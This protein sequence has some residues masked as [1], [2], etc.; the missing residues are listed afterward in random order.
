MKELN[1]TPLTAVWIAIEDGQLA[2]LGTN[3][4]IP[5]DFVCFEKMLNKNRSEIQNESSNNNVTISDMQLEEQLEIHQQLEISTQQQ[6][7]NQ[8]IDTLQQTESQE[9]TDSE[10]SYKEMEITTDSNSISNSLDIIDN[11]NITNNI[12]NASIRN[13]QQLLLQPAAIQGQGPY[14]GNFFNHN[15]KETFL[16]SISNMN[17]EEMIESMNQKSLIQDLKLNANGDTHNNFQ[18]S[19]NNGNELQLQQQLQTVELNSFNNQ[20]LLQSNNHKNSNN[21]INNNNERNML[22][23]S[24]DMNGKPNPSVFRIGRGGSVSSKHV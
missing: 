7:I 14:Y 11:Q 24:K 4:N 17:L 13:R 10:I 19:N 8:P 2:A 18:M 5:E 9:Q 16:P 15:N 3:I 1:G 22:L 21:N 12:V 6:A 23:Q 20:N